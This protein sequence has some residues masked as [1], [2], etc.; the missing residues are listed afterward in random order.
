MIKEVGPDDLQEALALVNEV[1]REFVAVDYSQE[2]KNTFANYLEKKH[3]ETALA[4]SSGN[5]KMWA[6]YQDGKILGVI[7]ARDVYH[8]SLLFVDKRHHK[9]GI[10]G[11]LLGALL[12]ELEN[13]EEAAQITVNSSP[14]AVKIYEKL[15][16]VRSGERQEK[17]GLIFIPMTRPK[18]L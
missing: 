12:K 13:H 7:A 10:A 2:G 3:E 1:F 4:L 5:K 16:F 14:Y 18:N 6:Y 15:G 11:Q 17:D 8:I 9:K